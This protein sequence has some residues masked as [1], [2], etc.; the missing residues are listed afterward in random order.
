MERKKVQIRMKKEKPA[1]LRKS[2]QKNGFVGFT[3][4]LIERQKFIGKIRSAEIYSSVLNRFLLFRN[5]KELSLRRIDSSLIREYEAH[6][7][8]KGLC[9][10]TV[11]FHMRTLCTIYNR[12]VEKGLTKQ[13]SP[14]RHVYTGT[15]K[16]VKRAVGR[17]S[18]RQIRDIDLQESPSQDFA[19]DMFLFSFYTRGMSFV[20][21][22]YL[23]KKDLQNDILTYRRQK[24][25]QQMQI[26]WEKQM[27]EILNKYDTGGTSYLLPIIRDTD[28]NIRRQYQTV[29]H[30]I[31]R[32]LKDLGKKLG[33][34]IPLTMYVARH[35]WASIAH[36]R[37]IPISVISKGMGHDSELTTQ[38]YLTSLN[39]S[40]VDKANRKV[41]QL[42]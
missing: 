1:I 13:R 36:S 34:S 19:R 9:P 31:N 17:E 14:F 3:R 29:S 25:G 37:N 23:K 32:Q 26:H 11:S 6:L 24:T 42:V 27:Q 28:K 40:E 41:I 5:G 39:T 38:I 20:D 33:F 22:A 18:I 15:C 21:M 2:S 12:A 30:R 4:N 7:K 8:V 35:S 16:T 10:N